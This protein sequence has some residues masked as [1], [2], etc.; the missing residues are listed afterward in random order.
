MHKYMSVILFN[1]TNFVHIS[2]KVARLRA[3]NAEI[4][5]LVEGVL[6][7]TGQ[8]TLSVCNIFVL[9]S[10]W[11]VCENDKLLCSA[12]WVNSRYRFVISMF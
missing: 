8:L 2:F 12:A 7:R 1:A 6:G 11:Q 3:K 9:T 10:L 4:S 5:L